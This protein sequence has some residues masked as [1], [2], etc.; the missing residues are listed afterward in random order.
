MRIEFLTKPDCE[1]SEAMYPRVVEVLGADGFVAVDITQLSLDDGRRGY[2][3]P[4]LWV[5][6]ADLFGLV[7]RTD[8]AAPPN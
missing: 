5:D 4:T 1:A 6:G 3:T 2:D 7:P 8:L